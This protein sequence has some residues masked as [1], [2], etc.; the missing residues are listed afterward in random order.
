MARR[1]SVHIDDFLGLKPKQQP[2]KT[3]GPVQPFNPEKPEGPSECTSRRPHK[4]QNRI[5]LK[6]GELD[7]YTTD[8]MGWVAAGCPATGWQALVGRKGEA[9]APPWLKGESLGLDDLS[10]QML[11]IALA[12]VVHLQGGLEFSPFE[13]GQDLDGSGLLRLLNL[14][15]PQG[16]WELAQRLAS[17]APLRTQGY[18]E[19]EG[20]WAS[21]RKPNGSNPISVNRFLRTEVSLSMSCLGSLLGLVNIE[22]EESGPF[23]EDLAL[24][25]TVRSTLDRLFKNPPPLDQPFTILMKGAEQSGR[26]TLAACL[27]KQCGRQLK[28][29]HASDG[30]KPGSFILANLNYHFDE[31][32]W[33]SLKGHPGWIFLKPTQKDLPFDAEA[34]ADLVLDLTSISMEDRAPLWERLLFE[35]GLD[36][37]AC[38]H[39]D[40]ITI[41][42]TPGRI[43]NLIK[44]LSRCTAWENLSPDD[45][46]KRLRAGLTPGSSTTSESGYTDKVKPKRRLDELCLPADSMTRFKRII[47][48]IQGRKEMLAN[49]DLDPGLLGR[50]QGV[51]LFH[52]PSGTGKTMAAEVL[53]HELG[54]PLWRLEAAEMES[55]FVGESEA[56]LH[57][58]FAG[59]KG[60]P[61]VL[62]LDEADTVL[63]NRNETTGSTQRY[64]NN[65]VNTWL[66]ELDGFEG[67][68]VLTTNHANSLDP[69]VERRIQY[70]MAFESP[71]AEV[72]AQI[73]ATLLGDAPIPGRDTLDFTAVAARYPF[74]GGRIRNAFV[75]ACQRA[76]EAGSI[77]QQVLNAA[78]EEEQQSSLTSQPLRTIRGFAAHTLE[79]A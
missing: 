70:R 74:S 7:A 54:L 23:I 78:C 5:R 71:S 25:K 79:S 75:D 31:D 42:A 4:G 68:L 30:H 21:R 60:K 45:L 18:L 24:P 66:R 51:L 11:A 56:R 20:Q 6:Q 58:L 39:K 67:I 63:M 62:L 12:H 19:V 55:P 32:D 27:A 76:A 59:V 44:K 72:R 15:P 22:D 14:I 50:A 17:D 3:Q 46:N 41:E 13:E 10:H 35:A 69:A 37:T 16:V 38:D 36:L 8:L 28:T 53:A 26:R 43:V 1:T 33:N 40:L 2:K 34:H 48:S 61:A 47:K 49:W 52:G 65:L 64:Q 77:I 73:W 29:V 57:S 9:A